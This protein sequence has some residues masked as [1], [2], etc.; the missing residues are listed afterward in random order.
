MELEQCLMWVAEI[1]IRTVLSLLDE[2]LAYLGFH[3]AAVSLGTRP[4]ENRKE[5]L[6]DRLG[7]KCTL[8]P[9][10]RRASD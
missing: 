1:S 4:S 9:E 3:W 8:R 6:G 10:C 2:T 5:G 7:R